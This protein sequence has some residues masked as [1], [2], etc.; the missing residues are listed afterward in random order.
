MSKVPDNDRLTTKALPDNP[1]PGSFQ[2]HL[3]RH[4]ARYVADAGTEQLEG[5]WFATSRYR[6]RAQVTEVQP[7]AP[8]GTVRIGLRVID[9]EPFNFQPGQFVG[10]EHKFKEAGYRRSPY[11]IMS[12]PSDEPVFDLLIR[13]VPNG[14][15]SRYLGAI[16]VGEEITFRGPT[17]RSMLPKDDDGRQRVLLATGTGIA[18]FVCLVRHL[19]AGGFERPVLLWWGLRSLD[20]VCLRDEFDAL[21]AEHPNFRYGISLSDPPPD[22]T[23]LVGRLTE[24]VPPLLES[25]DDKRFYLSGNGAMIED[26]TRALSDLGVVQKLIYK[27]PFFNAGY[28]ADPED[29]AAILDRFVVVH[30]PSQHP[31]GPEATAD[32][33]EVLRNPASHGPSELFDL[34]PTLISR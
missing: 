11:C 23:G 28:E 5:K 1:G 30:R 31:H 27:E 16:R 21:C 10:V 17:G 14:P 3:P 9:G 22:W 29:V 20:D 25:L 15:L 19:L 8:T 2:G 7:L 12:A 34:I 32:V 24:S 33:D 18:P 13:V 4:R 26:M 6:R